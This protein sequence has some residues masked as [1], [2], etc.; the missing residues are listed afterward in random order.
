MPRT[1]D[2]ALHAVRRMA[3]VQASASVFKGK[4]FHLAHGHSTGWVRPCLNCLGA[5]SIIL[6]LLSGQAFERE[7][8]LPT[9]TAATANAPADLVNSFILIQMP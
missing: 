1:N 8:G 9:K 3:I 2:E 7:L 4:G 6:A 5:A